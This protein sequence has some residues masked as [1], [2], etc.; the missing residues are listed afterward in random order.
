M[1]EFQFNV[2]IQAPDIDQAKRKLSGAIKIMKAGC[3]VLTLGDFENFADK[4]EKNKSR[5]PSAK[6]YLSMF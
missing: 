6:K 1:S 3:K 2:K 5:I 4:I